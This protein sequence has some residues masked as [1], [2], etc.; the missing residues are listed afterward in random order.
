MSSGELGAVPLC[1][2]RKIVDGKIVLKNHPTLGDVEASLPAK[3]IHYC[4]RRRV[5]PSDGRWAKIAQ[6]LLSVFTIYGPYRT[7][8]AQK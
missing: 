2:G 7:N 5:A 6:K 1:A 4:S 8:A 3:K